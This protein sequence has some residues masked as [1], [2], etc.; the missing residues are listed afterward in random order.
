MEVAVSADLH[1][2]TKAKN[3]ERFSALES[4]LK[5]LVARNI[6]QLI[7]AG[8]TFDE[9]GRNYAE[10]ESICRAAEF[11]HIEILLIPG[12]HDVDLDGG[13][14][15]AENVRVFAKTHLHRFEENSLPF[16][17]LPYQPSRTMGEDLAEHTKDLAA[18]KWILIGHGDWT[19]GLHERNP[20]EPGVYMPLTRVDIDTYQPKLAILGHIHKPF[21]GS[22]VKYVGSPCGLDI[23]ET[24][25]RRFLTVDTRTG[26]TA[27]H[28]VATDFIYF[29]ESFVVLPV[30]NELEFVATQIEQRIRSWALASEER[31]RARIQIK[32]SGYS[33][34][35]RALMDTLHAGFDGLRFYRD[36]EP[37]L[38]GVFVADDSGLAEIAKRVA[39][40]VDSFPLPEQKNQPEREE[41]LLAALKTIYG[42]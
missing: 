42:D 41:I 8:D 6:S 23:R 40:A 3:P 11:K 31:A 19:G 24:G 15:P 13:S 4:L 16:L 20:F 14:L 35:K 29:N 39:A 34:D 5:Q 38:S 28:T 10:F 7:L 36:G 32:L 37:D 27:A 22:V 2:T 30:D 9:S 12:N 21:D 17:L 18:G 1:L 26:K 25:R 33:A